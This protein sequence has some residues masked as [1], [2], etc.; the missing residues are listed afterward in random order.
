MGV[1]KKLWFLFVVSFV[2]LFRFECNSPIFRVV[3]IFDVSARCWK[4]K[5]CIKVKP[6][7][8]ESAHMPNARRQCMGSKH[9]VRAKPAQMCKTS[10]KLCERENEDS[11]RKTLHAWKHFAMSAFEERLLFGNHAIVMACN[12]IYWKIEYPTEVAAIS[13]STSSKAFSFFRIPLPLSGNFLHKSRIHSFDKL[14]YDPDS[15][16][17]W[18]QQK[19]LV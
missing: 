9:R 14:C 3:P 18:K 19:I 6:K 5:C 13:I 10:E 15:A 7:W 1:S 4:Q 8:M 12:Y 16:C 11:K 17:V 2:R